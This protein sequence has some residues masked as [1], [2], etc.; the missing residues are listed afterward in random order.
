LKE[1]DEKSPILALLKNHEVDYNGP[2]LRA[3]VRKIDPFH[4]PKK[5]ANVVFVQPTSKELKAKIDENFESSSFDF[6]GDA[7]SKIL[8]FTETVTGF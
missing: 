8:E 3:P 4:P 7:L 5:G 6:F 1:T 2:K